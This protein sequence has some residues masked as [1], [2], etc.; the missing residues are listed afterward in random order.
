METE[1]QTSHNEKTVYPPRE[2]KNSSY[3]THCVCICMPTEV[4]LASRS[5][6]DSSLV[7]VSGMPGFRAVTVAVFVVLPLPLPFLTFLTT[8]CYCSVT[9]LCPTLCDPMEC[10]TPGFP[11]LRYLP[12]LAIYSHKS[13]Q[14]PRVNGAADAITCAFGWCKGMLW[15]YHP[16]GPSPLDFVR[17]SRSLGVRGRLVRGDP[18]AP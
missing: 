14:N 7:A 12:E 15:G 11:V 2:K 1:A 5:Y 18:R 16:L 8:F 3:P 17:A 10:S 9:H 13:L 4:W 6:S